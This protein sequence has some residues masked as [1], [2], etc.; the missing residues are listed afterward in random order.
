MPDTLP[1]YTIGIVGLMRRSVSYADDLQR[2]GQTVVGTDVHPEN[3]RRFEDEYSAETY[4]NPD[5]MMADV[6]GVFVMPPSKFQEGAIITALES[7]TDVLAAK[8]MCASINSAKTVRDAAKAS[9]AF[10]MVEY[11]NRFYNSVR[12][13]QSLLTEETSEQLSHIE[14]RYTRQR[15]VPSRGSWFT[16]SELAGGGAL[17]DVGSHVLDLLFLALGS[18]AVEQVWAISRSEFGD[19]QHYSEDQVPSNSIY[20]FETDALMYDV[21]DSMTVMLQFETGQTAVLEIAWAANQPEEQIFDLFLRGPEESV[22]IDI[23]QEASAENG[24]LVSPVET[25][26][27]SENA[28]SHFDSQTHTV[29]GKNAHQEMQRTFLR[30]IRQ[31]ERPDGCS[32]DEAVHI[33]RIIDAIYESAK[34]G[35]P[36]SV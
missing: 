14:A 13:L 30:G 8:P 26:S 11:H 20:R 29:K 22:Y 17:M 6:D 2:L 5:A 25:Y 7:G 23:W 34:Q 31:G 24:T 33:H 10:C 9:S 19:R 4:E 21:E 3:R 36:I 15:G 18:S 12:L 1:E 28:A 27:V 16:S 35:T 32:V